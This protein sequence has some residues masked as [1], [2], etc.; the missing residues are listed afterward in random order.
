MFEW[1][2]RVISTIGDSPAAAP[3]MSRKHGGGRG[4]VVGR[5]R[6]RQP[7]ARLWNASAN[8]SRVEASTRSSGGRT[9]TRHR[10]GTSTPPGSGR[11]A[12]LGASGSR[13]IDLSPAS[14]FDTAD[15]E[16]RPR[17]GRRPATGAPAART[18][19][20]PVRISVRNTARA[21]SS[22]NAFA[23][24]AT[25]A[26]CEDATPVSLLRS[27]CRPFRSGTRV[28]IL[29]CPAARSARDHSPGP[30]RNVWSAT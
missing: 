11:R 27:T 29:A 22:V 8:V 18:C 7:R 25:S 10:R 9:R 1:P 5:L 20:T 19:G 21:W 28:S 30:P 4:R 23:T 17:A 6:C 26:G 14:D 12:R 3:F 2:A 16:A 24:Q 13:A 15:A